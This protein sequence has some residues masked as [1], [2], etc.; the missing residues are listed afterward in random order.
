M[1]A[2]LLLL[3]VFCSSLPYVSSQEYE[4][5]DVVNTSFRVGEEITYVLSYTWFFI[6]TDVGEAKFTVKSE[7][8][9]GVD[10]LHLHAVGYS[11]PFYDWFFKVRDL[12][13]SWVNPVTLKPIYFNRDIYEG[14]FTKEN[15]YTFNWPNLL[16]NARE[17]RRDGP[18]L[19]ES[20][21]LEPCTYDIV[22][23]IYATRNLDFKDVVAGATFPVTI[24][25]DRELY[26]A[27]YTFVGRE[28]KN[29][30]GMGRFKTMKFRVSLIAGDV[31]EEGQYMFV[32]VS[33]DENHIPLLVESPIIVGTVRARVASMRGLRH[34]LSSQLK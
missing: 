28:V 12:Y 19:F 22:S 15:E 25:L 20:V 7:K 9:L 3:L 2:I 16:V 27:N 4:K 10:A 34:G 6:W 23:A 5:C 14:G 29:V 21:R 8:K 33:D 31:F 26:H 13:E 17:K 24:V 30:K 32:W 1:R 11:Y 18:N